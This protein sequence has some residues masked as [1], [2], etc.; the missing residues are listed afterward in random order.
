METEGKDK[1]SHPFILPLLKPCLGNVM[2]VLSKAYFPNINMGKCCRQALSRFLGNLIHRLNFEFLLLL[3][4]YH[5]VLF[6]HIP[7]FPIVVTPLLEPTCPSQKP[8]STF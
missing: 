5:L 1:N 4:F 6:P 7:T 2:V 3:L 8:D